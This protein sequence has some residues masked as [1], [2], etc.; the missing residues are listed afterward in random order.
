[1]GLTLKLTDVE[2]PA[3]PAFIEFLHTSLSGEE[4]H[5]GQWFSQEEEGLASNKGRFED[6]QKKAKLVLAN[7]TGKALVTRSYRYFK[8]MLTGSPETL[9]NI[10]RFRFFFVVGIPRTGGTYLTKQLFRACDIDYT[11]VQNALAHDGFPHLSHLS[12]KNKSNIQTNGLLQLAEYLTMVEMYFTKFGKLAHNGGIVVPKKM[13]KAVYNFPLIQQLFGQ[14]ANYIITLRHPLS[15]VKS[16][17]DKSGGM[18]EDGKFAVRSAIER[19]AMDDWLD[20]G[21]SEKAVKDMDY[22]EV[23]L[24]YWQRYHYKLAL[25]GIPS[26]PTSRIVVFGKKTMMKYVSDIY[27][28]LNVDLKPEPFKVSKTAKF[29]SKHEKLATKT[30]KNVENLWKSLDLDFP[31]KDL[32]EMR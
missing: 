30:I 27:K 19:W 20:R 6:I 15:M 14:N 7:D 12:F 21:F 23:F 3:S 9:K 17:L 8:E 18:P 25:A 4:F 24:G 32:I 16:V 31:A 2:L 29:D 28:E 5:V 11:K 10:S 13:T 1:M 22:I 26:M